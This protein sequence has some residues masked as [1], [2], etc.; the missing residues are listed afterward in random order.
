MREKTN[1][2][3]FVSLRTEEE[4]K[5]MNVGHCFGFHRAVLLCLDRLGVAAVLRSAAVSINYTAGAK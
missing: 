4:D 3:H 2:F 5:K 1:N